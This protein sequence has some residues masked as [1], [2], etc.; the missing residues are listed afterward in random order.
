MTA[1][2]NDRPTPAGR[3]R[4]GRQG[5]ALL[6]G[7]LAL[8]IIAQAWPALAGWLQF[9]RAAVAAGQW[10]RPLTCH[11]THYGWRHLGVNLGVAS[12]LAAVGVAR[13]GRVGRVVLASAAVCGLAVLLADSAGIYR[14][15]S[16]VACGLAAW[17]LLRLAA[18]ERGLLRTT[19]A[20]ALAGTWLKYVV[21]WL[22]FPTVLA[23]TVPAGVEVTHVVHIAG[24]TAGTLLAAAELLASRRGTQRTSPA[25]RESPALR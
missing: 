11:L 4:E 23:S 21:E 24:L 5:G 13:F 7:L 14:G 15:V 20:C 1:P 18:A 25:P 12:I 16:G 2:R 3:V 19:F 22:L 9:D 17:L 8:A 10:W 6:A